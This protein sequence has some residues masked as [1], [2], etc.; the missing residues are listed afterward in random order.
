MWR[1]DTNSSPPPFTAIPY[2]PSGVFD[3]ARSSLCCSHGIALLTCC[4]AVAMETSGFFQVV[5]ICVYSAVKYWDPKCS[6]VVL[7]IVGYLV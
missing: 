6:V 2:C 5:D 1:E 4:R 7:G 3:L